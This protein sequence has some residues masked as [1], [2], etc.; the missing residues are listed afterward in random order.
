MNIAKNIILIF[1]LLCALTAK[2]Q[3]IGT[4][5]VNNPSFEEY[6]SCPVS[7]NEMYKCKYWWGGSCEYYN[8]C[9]APDG[10]SV[11]SNIAGFQYAN[12]GN[13]YAG[14]CIYGKS[15]IYPDFR[16]AIK[17]KLSDSLIINKRYCTN[18]YISLAN[19]DIQLGNYIILDSV[20]ML[21]TKDSVQDNAL[22]IISNGIKVQNNIFNIDTV[23]WLKITNTFI[24]NGGE[25]YLTIGNFDNVINWPTGAIGQDYVYVD[26]V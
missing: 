11:P 25:Q 14:A 2:E 12:T 16:E 24:A 5:L 22:P 10:V 1:I 9:A 21:F 17:T 15:T 20:G 23:N 8:T 13:A 6:Y 26:D 3:I 7:T 19:G 18:F 4:N